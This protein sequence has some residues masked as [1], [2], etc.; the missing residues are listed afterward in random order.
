MGDWFKAHPRVEY[1]DRAALNLLLRAGLG[2]E[3]IEK[4]RVFYPYSVKAWDRPDTI[5]FAYY[6]DS[7]YVWLVYLANDILDPY[8]D[9]VMTEE[10]LHA[11]VVDKYGSYEHAASTVHHYEN[12]DPAITYWMSPETRAALPPAERIGF[13]TEVTIWEYEQ[14][15]NEDRRSIRLLDR[16]Y[17][18]Q[19]YDELR[20][21]FGGDRI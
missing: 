12:T 1:E 7:K 19:A 16:R 10:D 11:Y 9:W 21:V 20:T 6:G 13:D 3:V 14:A 15:R 17:A 2:R 4:Y 5:A 8:V 18:Q